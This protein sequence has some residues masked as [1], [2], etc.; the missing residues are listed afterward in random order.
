MVNLLPRIERFI[1]GFNILGMSTNDVES[2]RRTVNIRKIIDTIHD[3]VMGDRTLKVL[4]IAGPVGIASKQLYNILH[5][6]RTS[7]KT[8]T[9]DALTGG[10]VVISAISLGL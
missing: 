9:C 10:F 3:L 4:E 6:I 1:S 8:K 2:I 5:F 7:L